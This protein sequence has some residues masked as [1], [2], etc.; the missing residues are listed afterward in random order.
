MKK[1]LSWEFRLG[2]SLL[3]VT[4]LLNGL[5]Y[6]IFRDLRHIFLWGL[7]SLA[8]LPMSVL[9]VSLIIERLLNAREAGA[10]LEK[11]N[12]LI[13]TFFGA[14]GRQLLEYFAQWDAEPFDM[15]TDV[16]KAEDWSRAVHLRVRERM[17]H[18]ACRVDM[19]KANLPE[20]KAFLQTRSDLLLRLLE[21][22][23]LLEHAA[24]A[25]A[26][27]AIFHLADELSAR[28]TLDTVAVADLEH[29]AGDLRRAYGALALQWVDHM[30][31]LQRNYPYLFSL[32]IRMNPFN[33]EA[34][35]EVE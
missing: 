22:P 17:A 28:R 10:R 20:L 13:G 3:A 25:E 19:K 32:A 35:P 26:L 29:L 4:V 5:H 9:F 24:F 18:H 23:L 7:T 31:Y 1:Q 15:R 14:A 33:P 2:L 11:T 27:R 21:N 12:M 16:S 34:S 8:F 6:A 30:D